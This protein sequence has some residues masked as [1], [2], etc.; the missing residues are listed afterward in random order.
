MAAADDRGATLA[1]LLA[2]LAVTALVT[3][4]TLPVVAGAFE[5]ERTLLAAQFV[6]A[7][8]HAARFEA[9]RRS[10]FVALRIELSQDDVLVQPF[11]D[12]N[13]NGVLARDVAMGLD[14][15]LAPQDRLGS[16]ARGITLRINRRVPD[17]G[18]A[19]WLETGSDPLRIGRSSLLS[20]APTGSATAGTLYVAGAAGPQLAVRVTGTTGRIRVLRFDPG[21]AT[22]RP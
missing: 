19:G 14:P 21:S 12:G 8:A 3:A 10:S 2:V 1:E 17:I 6:A 15:P 13:G 22:W 11:V 5:A 20:F 9:L 7:R 18:G 16:H 4:T